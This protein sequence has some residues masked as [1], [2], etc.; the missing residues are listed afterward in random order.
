LTKLQKEIIQIKKELTSQKS[1]SEQIKSQ[2]S[3]LSEQIKIVEVGQQTNLSKN[4]DL[5]E[6]VDYLYNWF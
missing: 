2:T 5:S 3:L 6:R 1:L 4:S